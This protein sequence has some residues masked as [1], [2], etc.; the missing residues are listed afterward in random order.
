MTNV[1]CVCQRACVLRLLCALCADTPGV[2]LHH[3][4]PHMLTPDELKLLHPRKRLKAYLPPTPL[5]L[6]EE[7][8]GETEAAIVRMDGDR[9]SS[10]KP[11]SVSA[12]YIWS[13][14]ARIDVLDAPPNMSLG[15]LGPPTM[16]TFALPLV[17]GDE[18]IELDLGETE[19]G[20]AGAE[21]AS[22]DATATPR[23]L[24]CSQSVAARGGLVP[25]VF[26]VKGGIP[27]AKGALADI[28]ISGVPGW[29]A[30]HCPFSKRDISL[31]VW[32]PRGVEAFLRPPLPCPLPVSVGGEQRGNEDELNMDDMSQVLAGSRDLNAA[33][34][35]LAELGFQEGEEALAE[36]LL[37]GGNSGADEDDE[38]FTQW[39][40]G[41]NYQ[42][43]EE[44]E[45]L[46][47]AVPGD[48]GQLAAK[49]T[50]GVVVDGGSSSGAPSE[51]GR[52]S[53]PSRN[54]SGRGGGG[55]STRGG[56]RNA[57]SSRQQTRSR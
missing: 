30:V 19:E 55:S 51:N 38:G 25:H 21:D 26:V 57:G 34:L 27:G 53:K 7:E 24:V 39:Y 42:E 6:L 20:G 11:K 47:E 22:S 18:S 2:H 49:F 50:Q 54:G 16:R 14:L 23:A 46:D 12:T 4:I 8:E 32:V 1:G 5:Q 37:F 52:S 45:M 15:F 44:D 13:G 3:R 28:A 10:R 17:K 31:R 56:K 9:G 36:L 35:N 43:G 41:G 48:W 33:G 40:E 29:V